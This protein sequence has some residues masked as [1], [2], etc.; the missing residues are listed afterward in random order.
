MSLFKRIC[1]M[2]TSSVEAATNDNSQQ[3]YNTNN[4]YTTNTVEAST[5]TLQKSTTTPS[6]NSD[7][8]I[9]KYAFNGEIKSGTQIT[10]SDGEMLVVIKDGAIADLLTTGVYVLNES[11]VSN[12]VTGSVYTVNLKETDEIKWATTK[13][14]DFND[15][16]YG[17]LSLRILG[18][19]SYS[20]CDVVKFVNDYMLLGISVNDYTRNLLIEAFE[21]VICSLNGTSYTQLSPANIS[22][23]V[24]DELRNT[25]LMFRVNIERIA[26]TEESKSVIEQAMKNLI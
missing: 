18:S 24:Q 10:V 3:T 22:K 11:N 2:F 13:P 17:M 14:I 19:Y 26:L 7:D 23:L 20:I 8:I 15:N 6:D 12:F 5:A 16:R 1:S 21:K 4:T 9:S 25:G